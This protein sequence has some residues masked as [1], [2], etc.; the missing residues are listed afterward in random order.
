MNTLDDSDNAGCTTRKVITALATEIRR[1][2]LT[3]PNAVYL[4][5]ALWWD[6]KD[7][8]ISQTQKAIKNA[9]NAL[10]SELQL[11]LWQ[12]IY[13]GVAMHEVGHTLGLRHNFEGST[14][15]VNYFNGYWDLRGQG[16]SN[17]SPVSLVDGTS[18]TGQPFGDETPEQVDGKM[19]QMQNST[20]MDYGAK[21]NARF[22][23]V[24]HYDHAAIKYAYGQVVETFD[25]T[26]DLT[27]IAPYLADPA[28]DDPALFSK[29]APD[30]NPFDQLLRNVHYTEIPKMFGGNASKIAERSNDELE[31]LAGEA[32]DRENPNACGANAYCKHYFHGDYCTDIT[33]MVPYRFCSDELA[34]YTPTCDRWDEGVDSYEIVRNA[35]SDYEK[36]WPFWGN[37]RDNLMFNPQNYYSKVYRTFKLGQRHYQYWLSELARL[38]KNDWWENAHGESYAQDINGGLPGALGA[39]ISFNGIAQAF[40]RPVDS[41]YGL[42]TQTQRYE[43]FSQIDRDFFDTTTFVWVGEESGARMMYPSYSYAGNLPIVSTSGAIYDRL[44]AFEVLSDPTTHF[45]DTDRVGMLND[46]SVQRYLISYFTGFP[47]EMMNLMGALM[48]DDHSNFGW[49]ISTSADDNNE[50]AARKRTFVGPTAGP[51]DEATEVALF[52][53]PKYTFPTTKF[54]MPALAATYSMAYLSGQEGD[55][56]FLDQNFLD[57]SHIYLKDHG[58]ALT[59]P[60]GSV[61]TIEFADPLSGKIYV[62]HRPADPDPNMYYPGYKVI[63]QANQAFANF[64]NQEYYLSDL[65]YLVGKLELFRGTHSLYSYY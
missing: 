54:R 44:S 28:D 20:V 2:D 13:R 27:A 31:R 36:Y 59:P 52:P 3:S 8:R 14:D 60:A 12:K 6:T 16:D 62:A 48:T 9:I 49:C 42:N 33:A 40:G 7:D 11:E 30:P 38:D 29:F 58:H 39:S 35:F 19:R 4:P 45:V 22:S 5:K 24:G 37:M 46:E 26:P 21:F 47:L 65:Q 51:C 53:E 32:C 63:E 57:L 41:W 10:R 25:T 64:E 50:V 1:I 34:T 18:Q 17:W 56:S 55:K 43:P 23:G 15:A 61:E